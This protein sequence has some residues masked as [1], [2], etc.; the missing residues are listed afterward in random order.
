MKRIAVLTSGGD[1]LRDE[2]RHPRGGPDRNSRKGVEVFGVREGYAGRAS[3]TT[4]C[5]ARASAFDRM[6]RHSRSSRRPGN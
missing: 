6:L 5:P 1:S 2:R 3:T 4:S